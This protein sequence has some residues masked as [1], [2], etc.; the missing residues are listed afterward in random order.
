M[1]YAVKKE[2]KASKFDGKIAVGKD[3]E[4]IG[5]GDSF[6]SECLVLTESLD[7]NPNY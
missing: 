7:Q 1:F 4:I 3:I 6:K 2:G 5:G